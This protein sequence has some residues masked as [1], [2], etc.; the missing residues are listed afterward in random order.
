MTLIGLT[1]VIFI[2]F[3]ASS[4]WGTDLIAPSRSLS[5][6]IDEKAPLSVS[7]EPPGLGVTLDS[8]IIGETPVIEKEIEPGSHVVRIGDSETQIYARAGKPTKLSWFKGTFI[9]MPIKKADDQQQPRPEVAEKKAK[10]QTEAPKIKTG[11]NDAFYW[12]T[13]PTGPIAPYIR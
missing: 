1:F 3:G 10:P 9:E 11:K 5:G 7:S 8:T 2:L 4:V 13:N 6:P 12:P